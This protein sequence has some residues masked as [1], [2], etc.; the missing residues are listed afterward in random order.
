[1]AVLLPAGRPRFFFSGALLAL[2]P[3]SASRFK[4]TPAA[5]VPEFFVFHAAPD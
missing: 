5:T 1:V 3:R 4:M 2:T